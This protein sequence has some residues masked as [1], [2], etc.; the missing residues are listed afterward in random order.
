[1]TPSKTRNLWMGTLVLAGAGALMSACGPQDGGSAANTPAATPTPQVAAP[2]PAPVVQAPVAQAPV[3]APAEAVK[4][5][6]APAPKPAPV[7]VAK[8]APAKPPAPKAIPVTQEE[9]VPAVK[10]AAAPPSNTVGAVTQIDPITDSAP[11]GVGAVAGGALGGVLGHQFG[12]GDGKKA[13]TVLGAI[14]GAVAGHQVEKS[15]TTKVIGYRV[16]VQLD[17]GETRT[18]EWA[19]LDGLKVGDRV[20]VDQGQLRRV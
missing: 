4:P 17:N 3:E 13:M 16:Q 2:A 8:Q 6:P 10:V 14:G 5:A 11:T 1:M 18:F 9:P 7:H 19:Q 12:K 15:Y 20:R